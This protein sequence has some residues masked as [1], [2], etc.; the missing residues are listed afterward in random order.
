M[1]SSF[2]ARAVFAL[3]VVATTGAFFITQRLKRSPA[4]IQR[5]HYRSSFSPNG[6]GRH[7]HLAMR[8]SLRKAERVTVSVVDG[9]GDPV[10]TLLEDDRLSAG[11]HRFRWDGRT[12]D[13]PVAAEGPYRLRV[14]LRSE[15]RSA[16]VPR[17]VILDV[18][19][20]RPLLLGTAPSLL[21]PGARVPRGRALVRYAT[22]PGGPPLVTVY[23]TDRGR[24]RPVAHLIGRRGRGAVAWD[25]RVRGR[26][27]P[28]GVYAFSVTV[29]DP[30][31]NAGSAPAELPPTRASAGPRTGVT[32]RRLGLVGPLE[33]V[34][35]GQVTRF[36]LAPAA[37]RFRWRLAR[38]GARRAARRGRGLGTAFG[39]RVPRRARTGLYLLRVRT[40]AGRAVWP[41]AIRGRRRGRSAR[42]VVVVLPAIAWAGRNRS[43]VDGDG[44]ADT[45]DDGTAV[46]LDA[47]LAGGR[48]PRGFAGDVGPL[49]RLLDRDRRRYEIT[50]DLALA[51][52]RPPRLAGDRGVVF[53][54]DERW[55]PADLE[56][57]LRRYVER[58]G[59][60]ASFGTDAFRRRV[61][62]E[63]DRLAGATP[64]AAVNSLGER[65]TPP[66]A[67]PGEP[68]P[69][70]PLVAF[71][72]R[73]GLFAGTGGL[74][75]AFSRLELSAGLSPE[76]GGELA[77]AGRAG[78]RRHPAFIA[79]RLG[80]GIVVR[81]G[82]AGWG[83]AAA[84]R[85]DVANVT[86]RIWTLLSR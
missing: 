17:A 84:R 19:P 40:P 85:A 70:A 47:P 69:P 82:A 49:A 59:R 77:S 2:L 83:R 29:R 43:D 44:F 56:R 51:R 53:A 27:A 31:G 72:D 48:L 52:G 79:Y 67:Q 12:D 25:G 28:D 64:P 66:S 76:A 34:A 23:R 68:P 39:A 22:P 81:T 16:T 7:D 54:G 1:S 37:L 9:R 63:P 33:P 36:R 60:V 20:P 6:D 26:L 32:A 50:T 57:R 73:L 38:L 11:P 71:S 86:A 21:V 10:R 42:R 75:G 65:T 58:G 74:V 14:L 35:A 61:T 3:L 45:L 18:T 78:A 5:V 62:V 55:L 30:A 15:G 8:F 24:P 46:P 13:G 4:P 80:R 41:L